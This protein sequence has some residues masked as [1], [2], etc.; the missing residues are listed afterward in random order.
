[1]KSLRIVRNRIFDYWKLLSIV[2]FRISNSKSKILVGFC[3]GSLETP[4]PLWSLY[5]VLLYYI[6]SIGLGDPFLF[7]SK[8]LLKNFKNVLFCQIFYWLPDWLKTY[9]IY[10]SFTASSLI[11]CLRFFSH[12]NF[13]LNATTGRKPKC[14]SCYLHVWLLENDYTTAWFWLASQ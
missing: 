4:K 11:D 12:L 7:H 9:I 3:R 8:K 14:H 1:M 10:N 2:T 5:I 13:W 6:V